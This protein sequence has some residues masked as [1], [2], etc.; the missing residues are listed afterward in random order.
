MKKYPEFL[1]ATIFILIV[2]CG[3]YSENE[4]KLLDM[5]LK[6]I[7][8]CIEGYVVFSLTVENNE[9][10]NPKIVESYPEGVFDAHAKSSIR[11]IHFDAPDGTFI[12]EHRITYEQDECA[13]ED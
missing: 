13:E 11:R 6:D 7:N 12:P 10:V 3:S 9:A 5:H 8:E 1:T 2:S 4:D